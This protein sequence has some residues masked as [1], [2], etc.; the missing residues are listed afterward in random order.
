[1]SFIH[2]VYSIVRRVDADAGMDVLGLRSRA[3]L[4]LIGE[5]DDEPLRISDVVRLAGLGTP[6]TIYS[7]LAELEREGWIVKSADPQ[8]GRAS[9]VRLSV[10]AK[11]A[12]AKMSRAIIKLQSE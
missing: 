12:F 11:R 1:M 7:S 6:P 3:L 5:N 9:R 10:K 8:D 2:R 4:D